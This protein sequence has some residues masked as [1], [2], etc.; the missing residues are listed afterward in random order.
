MKQLIRFIFFFV[1][2]NPANGEQIL[3]LACDHAIKGSYQAS[4]YLSSRFKQED[5][6]IYS[7]WLLTS[8]IQGR[9]L[10][11]KEVQHLG[12]Q[13]HIFSKV[14]HCMMDKNSC[15]SDAM[16]AQK[17]QDQQFFN[18]YYQR[19]PFGWPSY[20]VAAE[21]FLQ[22]RVQICTGPHFKGILSTEKNGHYFPTKDMEVNYG[23]R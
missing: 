13:Q 7:F 3:H 12:R 17:H 21:I 14:I 19:K 6:D 16:S 9:L 23:S 15:F 18:E 5:D 22:N 8:S 4:Y 20:E 2:A 11:D 1:L 10:T